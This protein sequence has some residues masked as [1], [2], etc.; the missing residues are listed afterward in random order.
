MKLNLKIPI[1]FFDLET[2]GTNIQH[3]RIIEIAV[4]KVFPS[5]EIV[6]KA[7][8]INPGIPIPPESIMFHGITDEDVKGKPTFKEV[9]REYAKLFE[10]SDLSGF[11][12]MKFDVPV[13][14]EE[15]LRCDVE[16]DYSRKKIID[17]QK[18]FHMMEKRT[19]KA[20]Y[21]FYCNKDLDNSHSAES[22]T[23]ASMEVLLSQIERYENQDVTDTQGNKVGQI[24][25]DME[26]L[27]KLTS[28]GMV[29]LAG[30]MII[31]QKGDI[32]YNFGKHKGKE[33][34]SVFKEDPAFY[35]WV[36]NGDFSL[37]TKRK[38]TEIKLSMLRK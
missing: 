27:S 24:V 1:C 11:N 28:Q 20:A 30:R 7:N 21:R 26:V 33:V 16:F 3:D 6:R 19:L 32:I 17:S 2:T 31:T 18:I 13:L 25:N 12:I 14:V 5:G 9:A 37:D 22:D 15:F 4:T 35:D 36:M 34:K 23:D 8:L 10:G 29:D 38:L